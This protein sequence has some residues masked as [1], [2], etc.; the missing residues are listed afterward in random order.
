MSCYACIKNMSYISHQSSNNK[1]E[2][3]AV[4]IHILVTMICVGTIIE[5][6]IGNP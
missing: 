1:H 5:A 4:R 2:S 6:L 3:K